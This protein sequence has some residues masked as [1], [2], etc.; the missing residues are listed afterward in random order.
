MAKEIVKS[1]LEYGQSIYLRQYVLL[2]NQVKELDGLIEKTHASSSIQN[3][4]PSMIIPDYKVQLRDLFSQ[5][6]QLESQLVAA[7][8]FKVI[9]EPIVPNSPISPNKVRNIFIGCII[10]LMAGVF[11]AFFMEYWEKSKPK[12]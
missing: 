4:F 12:K 7:K 8:E 10:G 9:D 11:G 2:E 3:M 1:Y 6:F 5:K